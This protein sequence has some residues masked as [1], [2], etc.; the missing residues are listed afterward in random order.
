MAGSLAAR[1]PGPSAPAWVLAESLASAMFS[2]GSLLLIGRVIGPAAAGLGGLPI[3]SFLLLEIVAGALFSNSLVQRTALSHKHVGSAVVTS[4]ALGLLC[5]VLLVVVT[6]LFGS[7]AEVPMLR[8]LSLALAPLLPMAAFAGTVSGLLLRERQFR[9]LSLRLLIGQPVALACGLAAARLGGGAWAMV[10]VQVVAVVITFVL[11]LSSARARVRFAFD[12]SALR[13]LLRIALPSL[14][15]TF[16]SCGKYRFFLIGLGAFVAPAVLALSNFA[17]RFLDALLS[18]VFQGIGRIGVSNLCRLQHDRDALAEY[19]GELTRLLALIGFALC[20]GVAL[21]A[22]DLVCV[23]MGPA[24]APSG[25]ALVVAASVSS[26]SCLFGDY[27]SLFLAVGKPR[28]NLLLAI[29][30]M[31]VSISALLALRPHTPMQAALAWSAEAAVLA[32]VMTGLVLRELD[33]PLR[34]LAMKILPAV[35][36]TLAM[37]L[38][39]CLAQQIPFPD[40]V[41]RLI[42]AVA[43]GAVT[44]GAVAWIALGRTLPVAFTHAPAREASLEAV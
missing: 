28:L 29:F 15:G 36:A 4:L 6:P 44:Y 33:R 37:I 41:T 21:V 40:R 30:S 43:V 3:A 12:L 11:M 7:A 10:A 38:A 31:G 24:W 9:M 1:I 26:L 34:W 16:V 32:P 27:A 22:P 2:F 14:L 39:V 13:D 25:R 35:I 8:A 19:Y 20:A 23:L 17:F 18:L 5:A 42:S